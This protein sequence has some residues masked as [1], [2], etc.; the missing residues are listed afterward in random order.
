MARPVSMFYDSLPRAHF[1]FANRS[2]F[3]QNRHRMAQAVRPAPPWG[4]LNLKEVGKGRAETQ[5][6]TFLPSKL[7][8]K[9]TSTAS[10]RE[11]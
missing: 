9:S 6:V 10:V 11:I 5:L 8:P 4:D 7:W 2:S 3:C 1:G